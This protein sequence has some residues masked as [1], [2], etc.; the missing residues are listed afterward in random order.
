MD[1]K[2]KYLKYKNKYLNLKGGGTFEDILKKHG[3]TE[4]NNNIPEELVNDLNQFF[5]LTT[6]DDLLEIQD[7]FK[8]NNIIDTYFEKSKIPRVI[9]PTLPEVIIP[10]LPEVIIPTVILPN[11]L[12]DMYNLANSFFGTPKTK[13]IPIKMTHI[14]FKKYDDCNYHVYGLYYHDYTSPDFE[15]IK[16]L[17]T[18]L[19]DKYERYIRTNIDKIKI[20]TFQNS[21]NDIKKPTFWET[22][23][24][25][26]LGYLIFEKKKS[27]VDIWALDAWHLVKTSGLK[28]LCTTLLFFYEKYPNLQI[29]LESG[30]TDVSNKFYKPLGFE[31]NPS[32][33]DES[34]LILKDILPLIHEKCEYCSDDV[35]LILQ[36]N[37]DFLHS[38][39]DMIKII[40]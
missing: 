2:N 20:K 3:I 29:T 22:S 40:T 36:N 5:T 23:K 35:K 26:I 13:R 24:F 7:S 33:Q 21:L 39:E 11:Y 16:M 4:L 8:I 9:I 15:Q 18:L 38:S 6:W 10:T 25:F 30:G 19:L 14:L 28:M 1:Y 12:D 17:E 34:L 32:S 31:N 37:D 27:T